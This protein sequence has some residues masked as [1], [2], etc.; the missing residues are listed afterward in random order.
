MAGLQDYRSA[1]QVQIKSTYA[2]IGLKSETRMWLAEL[3]RR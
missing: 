3:P 2:Q 1:T